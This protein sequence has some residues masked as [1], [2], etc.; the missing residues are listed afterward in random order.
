MS[1][2]WISAKTIRMTFIF[3]CV[4]FKV[5]WSETMM[6]LIQINQKTSILFSTSWITDVCEIIQ[7]DFKRCIKWS[8]AWNNSTIPIRLLILP[9]STA[10]DVSLGL[11]DKNILVCRRKKK[12]NKELKRIQICVMNVDAYFVY[13]EIINLVWVMNCRNIQLFGAAF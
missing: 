13:R 6:R 12:M 11:K 10:D 4:D 3:N 8:I 2:I 1:I 5:I 9:L 7:A